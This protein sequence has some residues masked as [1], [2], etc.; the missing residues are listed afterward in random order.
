MYNKKDLCCP[1][2]RSDLECDNINYLCTNINCQ[3]NYP[4]IN[5]IPIL[6]DENKSIFEIK[7]FINNEETTFISDKSTFS[8]IA[9]VNKLI[10]SI[11]ANYVSEDLLIRF[12]KIINNNTKKRILIIGGSVDGIGMRKFLSLNK[13]NDI[14]ITDVS[15]GGNVDIICDCHSLPFQN[16]SIDV[17]II[18]AVLEHVID[19]YLCVSELSRVLKKGGYLLSEVPFMQQLHQAPYDFT[20]FTHLGHRW[21]FKYYEHITSGVVCGTGMGLTWSLRG[22]FRTLFNNRIL[23]SVA[24]KLVHI[25]FFWIKYFDIR[26]KTEL[27]NGFESASSLYFVGKLNSSPIDFNQLLEYYHENK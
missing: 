5:E 18:Q 10:P 1:A 21:L 11:N 19:P 20:R 3:F 2:C 15:F 6:I 9:K 7:S 12:S 27:R 22:F 25:L 16:D 26:K 13:D 24:V 17:V 8:L 14:I 23:Q 4:L